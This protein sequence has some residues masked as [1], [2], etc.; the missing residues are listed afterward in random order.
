MFPSDCGVLKSHRQRGG[1]TNK[2][3][4]Y[5]GYF[6]GGNKEAARRKG[7]N[8]VKVTERPALMKTCFSTAAPP[9]APPSSPTP[10]LTCVDIPQ[11]WGQA[12][13]SRLPIPQA[14][15]LI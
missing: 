10:G 6:C 7:S 9:V 4:F 11:S 1:S 8:K 3:Q 13:S 15:F 14:L 5:P 12:L 2:T